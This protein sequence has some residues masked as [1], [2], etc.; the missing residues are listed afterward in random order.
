VRGPPLRRYAQI[1]VPVTIGA[2]LILP[3]VLDR[4][5]PASGATPL[6]SYLVAPTTGP[7]PTISGPTL[8]GGLFGPADYRGHVVV[9]NF[10]N[11]DCPPC[12]Q[13]APALAAADA[14]LRRGG[15]VVFIGVMYVGGNWP[16]D[17]DGAR[18]FLRS[19]GLT[20]PDIVDQGG[21]LATSLGIPGIP[22][23]ILADAS[24]AMRYRITGGVQPGE[25]E[26][27]VGTLGS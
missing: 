14:K 8:A 1:L 16:D 27:L 18:S 25:L 4:A 6:A 23:T 24:G 9:V 7:L 15:G 12:R 22:V 26:R 3:R 20:Y 11:P 21:A 5:T 13:E 2:A 19:F 17:R 10:W